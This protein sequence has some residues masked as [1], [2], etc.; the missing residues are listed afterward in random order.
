MHASVECFERILLDGGP[1]RL[2]TPS[3]V[4]LL[5]HDVLKMRLLFLGDGEG[6]PQAEVDKAFRTLSELLSVMELATGLLIDN[7][8]RVQGY[9]TTK[10]GNGAGDGMRAFNPEVLK[11]ILSH[12]AERAASKFLKK[13]YSVPKKLK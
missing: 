12:R 9:S 7:F 13:Y 2:F 1:Y 10:A 11:K 3:D 8:L 4:Q 5:E 6:L